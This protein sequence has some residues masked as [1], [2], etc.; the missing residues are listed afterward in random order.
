VRSV[1]LVRDNL[2]NLCGAVGGDLSGNLAHNAGSP[3]SNVVKF[4]FHPGLHF[5]QVGGFYRAQRLAALWPGHPEFRTIQSPVL[6]F[7]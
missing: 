6:F 4:D 2:F 3:E 1:V 5:A 7:A